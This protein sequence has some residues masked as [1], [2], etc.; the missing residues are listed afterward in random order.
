MA[1]RAHQ[2][3]ADGEAGTLSFDGIGVHDLEES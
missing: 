2:H 3:R 1:Y